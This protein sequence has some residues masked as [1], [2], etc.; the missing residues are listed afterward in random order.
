MLNNEFNICRPVWNRQHFV[1]DPST[2]RRRARP[3][4]AASWIVEEV[5]DL[6]IVAQELWNAV[7]KRQKGI[8]RSVTGERSSEIRSERARRPVYLFSRLLKCWPCRRVKGR[9]GERSA[10]WKS[11]SSV[12]PRGARRTR[13]PPGAQGRRAPSASLKPAAEPDGGEGCRRKAIGL[14]SPQR[15]AEKGGARRCRVSRISSRPG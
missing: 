12:D 2:G 6:R 4:S 10:P 7:E 1:K 5:P 15:S 11:G 13:C 14:A 8:R 9:T 3:N